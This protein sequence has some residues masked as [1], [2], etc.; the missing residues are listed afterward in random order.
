M[1]GVRVNEK[2]KKSLNIAREVKEGCRIILS[3]TPLDPNQWQLGASK[4]FIRHPES[5][6]FLEESLERIDY[7]AAMII[8]KSY[9]KLIARKQAIHRTVEISNLLKG[10][11]DR[12]SKSKDRRFEGMLRSWR[13]LRG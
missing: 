2:K 8:Q 10:K 5:L 6:F 12:R 4:V 13:S 3:G 11:K 1:E 7:D 9:R